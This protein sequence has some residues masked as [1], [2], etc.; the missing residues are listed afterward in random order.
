MENIKETPFALTLQRLEEQIDK[1]NDIADRTL[2]I[3]DSVNEPK[4]EIIR[5]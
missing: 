1:L 3:L 4:D 5:Y 2:E